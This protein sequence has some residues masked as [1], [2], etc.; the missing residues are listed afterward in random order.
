MPYVVK[1]LKE[2][3]KRKSEILAMI[4]A[5]LPDE[6]RKEIREG[7]KKYEKEAEKIAKKASVEKL[8]TIA[9]YYGFKV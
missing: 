4:L 8:R 7:M 9:R 5:M 2:I 1:A 3:G 6:L